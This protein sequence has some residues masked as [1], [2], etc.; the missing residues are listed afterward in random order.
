M[1]EIHTPNLDRLASEGAY[2]PNTF[3]N[4][5][6]CCPARAILMTGTYCH[7]NG[8]VAN[9][10]RLRE[11]QET[12]AEWLKA[13]GYRTGFIGKWH[14]DGGQRLPGFVPPGPRRQGFD[15]WAANECDHRPFKTH[16][17]RDDDKPIPLDKFEAEGWVD[18][19]IEFLEQSR[20]DKR[21]FCLMLFMGPPHDPYTAPEKYLQM[22]SPERITMRPNWHG[23]G[24]VPGR[25][26]IA[27][28]YAAITA[29]DEQI[30][31]FVKALDDSGFRD[32]TI[33]MVSSDH[34][35]MLGS[36][37]LRLKRKPWEESIRVPGII[38]YPRQIKPGK[39]DALFSHIDFVPTML[40]LCGVKQPRQIQGTDLSGYLT[41][42]SQKTPDSV[43]FQIFGPFRGDGTQFSWRGVRTHD[44]MYARTENSPW[45][46]YD[47]KKDPFE[48]TNLATDSAAE[49]ARKSLDGRLQN[50]MRTTGDSWKF[51]WTD[52][53]EDNGRLYKH[54]TFYS[55][56][57]YLSWAREHPEAS[58][59][60]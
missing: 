30:G 59:S 23:E 29:V 47:L 28:Y 5:P 4:T 54:Q 37:G 60:P 22:Y 11:S 50:W 55:V 39:R 6:V 26:E 9:D 3:A 20:N 10:L 34:G 53:V 48:M 40:G 49:M 36:Q 33:L 16:Y 1:R 8:M 21:P 25:K 35:D 51:N 46:F 18:R 52:L 43:F 15:Y 57:E 38:R 41:G 19:G 13:A 32:D 44:H 56:D 27:A 24:G 12:I 14:L 58:T 45:V 42:R 7:V 2:L 17:F 31:R